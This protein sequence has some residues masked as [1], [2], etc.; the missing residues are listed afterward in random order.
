M[1]NI[2]LLL[3]TF[4]SSILFVG[5]SKPNNDNFDLSNLKVPISNQNKVSSSEITSSITPKKEIIKNK[6]VTY[7]EVSEILDSFEIGK[8]DP[9]SKGGNKYNKLTTDL[10]LTGFLNT[11]I[12]N[13]VFVIYQ[14]SEGALTEESIGGVN[15]NLLPKGAEVINIDPINNKLTLK[16]EDENYIFKL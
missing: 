16:F 14:N 8:V 2:I 12:N 6:L 7:P 10:K 9:F 4:T 1:K 13:Y 3:L 15:T 11:D 5:C